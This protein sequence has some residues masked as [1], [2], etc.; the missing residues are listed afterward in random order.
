MIACGNSANC[1]AVTATSKNGFSIIGGTWDG[2]KGNN[3]YGMAQ[4]VFYFLTCTNLAIKDLIVHDSAY[5]NV[6]CQSCTG[7]TITGIESYAPSEQCVMLTYCANS[8][9]ENCY[10]HDAPTKGGIYAYSEDDSTVQ[11]I[12]NHIF[13]NNVVQNTYTTGISISLRG[14]EDFGR[15]NVIEGNICIDCGTD[16]QHPGITSGS[17]IAPR[18]TRRNTATSSG[19]SST[20]P[21]PAGSAAAA[22]CCRETSATPATT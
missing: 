22:S 11:T 20:N 7:T 17:I 6:Y 5:A 21:A 12:N 9:V 18:T 15:Y 16:G 19:T 14:P 4:Q 13:V 1:Y 8:W 10:L 3:T 2:N